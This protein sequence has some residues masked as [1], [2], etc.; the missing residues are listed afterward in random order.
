MSETT[1]ERPPFADVFLKDGAKSLILGP[2]YFDARAVVEH[3]L[4]G[5]GTTDENLSKAMEPVIKKFA[6]DAY[7]LMSERV[8]SWLFSD[9]SS[10]LQ[11]QVWRMVD[12]C[13]VALLGGDSWSLEKYALGDRYNLGK[14]RETIARLIPEELQ[15]MRIAELEKEL[16]DA[17]DTIRR[18]RER[19]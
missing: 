19:Y 7:E 8:Q 14:I 2:A 15:N 6:D 11:G 12:A 17:N 5:N 4:P 18:L 3:V 16:A 1:T 10:N 13:V 9:V